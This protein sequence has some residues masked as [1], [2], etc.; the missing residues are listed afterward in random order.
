V[1][2]STE[3]EA[4]MERRTKMVYEEAVKVIKTVNL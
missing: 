4:G 2:W 3:V 1:E